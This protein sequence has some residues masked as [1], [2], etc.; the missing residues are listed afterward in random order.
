MYKTS[1]KQKENRVCVSSHVNEIMTHSPLEGFLYQ[2]SMKD[3]IINGKRELKQ[4]IDNLNT[5][6]LE[7][8]ILHK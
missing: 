7:D 5:N 2:C 1:M 6:S 4:P 3:I 8:K